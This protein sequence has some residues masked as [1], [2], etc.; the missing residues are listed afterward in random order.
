MVSADVIV[1]LVLL[2]LFNKYILRSHGNII[3]TPVQIK[4]VQEASLL[5]YVYILFLTVVT[6]DRGKRF[7][8]TVK[9]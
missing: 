1:D 4:Y 7:V 5:S 3:Y 8:D 9:H 2:F 6:Q